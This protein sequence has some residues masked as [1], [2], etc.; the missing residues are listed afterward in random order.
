MA[1]QISSLVDDLWQ[2]SAQL[3]HHCA[4]HDELLLKMDK[5]HWWGFAPLTMQ[6][7]SAGDA[8]AV[9]QHFLN[10]C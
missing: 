1:P 4:L 9:K 5:T 3:C 2:V 8:T 7:G 6:Q 10:T